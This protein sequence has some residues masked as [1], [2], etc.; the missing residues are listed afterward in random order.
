MIGDLKLTR[1]KTVQ[2]QLDEMACG[3][4]RTLIA[5]FEGLL[6][7]LAAKPEPDAVEVAF[8]PEMGHICAAPLTGHVELGT[9]AGRPTPVCHTMRHG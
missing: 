3:P 8:F 1:V 4:R 5:C 7:L 2:G 9:G 6:V